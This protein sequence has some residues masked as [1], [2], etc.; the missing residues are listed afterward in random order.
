MSNDV[1]PNDDLNQVVPTFALDAFL[2]IILAAVIGAY[3]AVVVL[4]TWLPGLSD[5]LLGTAPKAYW[6]LARAT[7][8][9]AYVLLW[10]SMAFGLTIKNKMAR[11]WPG[12]PLAVDL[13]QFASLF[14]LALSLFHALVLLG[15]RYMNYT[16]AQILIPFTNPT[17]TFW[18]GLG[19]LSFYIML[20]V[21]FSFYARQRIGFKTWRTIHYASFAIYLLVTLHG[22]FSGTDTTTPGMMGLY[23]LTVFATYF[24]TVFRILVSVR[25]PRPQTG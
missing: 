13:H 20:P 18:T 15:D 25:V 19:Q 21:A 10:I 2:L 7:G 22:I 12:G 8:V 6:Y 5:S 14:A 11:V 23:A 16:P 3:A 17:L 24:L 4:P 1:A 9:I